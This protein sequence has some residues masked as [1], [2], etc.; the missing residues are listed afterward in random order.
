M[1]F[2]VYMFAYAGCL[3]FCI[4]FPPVWFAVAD[5]T[6]ENGQFSSFHGRWIIVSW[7]PAV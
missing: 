2:F 5:V 1:N 3:F 4:A 7:R 6:F